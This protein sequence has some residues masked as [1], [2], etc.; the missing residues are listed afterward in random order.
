MAKK[1]RGVKIM[2]RQKQSSFFIACV[3]EGGKPN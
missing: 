1:L 3:A 2:K